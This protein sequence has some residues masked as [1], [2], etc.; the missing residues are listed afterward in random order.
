MEDIPKALRQKSTPQKT[1]SFSPFL[2]VGGM[3]LLSLGVITLGLAFWLRPQVQSLATAETNNTTSE[4]IVKPTPTATPT[5][6]PTPTPSIPDN[7]LG[8]LSYQEAPSGDL[9]AITSDQRIKLRSAAAEKFQQ[10]QADAQAEGIN[11]VPLSGYRSR[12]DQE[13][14]FFDI[15]EKRAQVTTKRAEVSAPPGYSEHHTGYAIDIGDETAPATHLQVSFQ[16]TAAFRWLQANA[17]RYSFELSFPEN[18][19]Q[20]I[21][22]EPW[23]WRFVGNSD[24]LETYY[25]AKN[26]NERL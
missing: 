24:S 9:V 7:L 3:F 5:P 1:S 15:K 17:A 20:G 26:L 16:E 4:P 14:L 22:Y 12:A 25:K 23:H 8:H 21:S 10:M 13:H 6:I 18:N 2:L 19:P 11:L